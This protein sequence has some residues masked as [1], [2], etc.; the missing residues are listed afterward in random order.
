MAQLKEVEEP[1]TENF[2]L[3]TDGTDWL[4]KEKWQ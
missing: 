1:T 2:C 3:F 4:G